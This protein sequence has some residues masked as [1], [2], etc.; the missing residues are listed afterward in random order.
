[1][2][3][4]VTIGIPVYMAVDY[5]GK[6]MESA[7]N[8]SYES[9]EY[10]I[11]DDCGK[12]GSIDIVEKI[13]SQHLRGKD[14]RILYNDQNCGV[15][16]TRN[17]ILEEAHGKYLYYLDSDDI[18]EPN[19]IMLLMDTIRKHKADVAYG[20]LERINLVGKTQTQCMILPNLFIDSEDGMATYAF[21]NYNSFPISVCNCLMS[22]AF[23]RNNNLHFINAAYWEDWAFTYDMVVKVGRAVLLSYITYHYQCRSG[24]LS[25]YQE[26]DYLEKKEILDNVSTM[27]YMKSRCY[28]LIGKDYLPYLC[29]NLEMNCFYIIC[30]IIK[31]YCRIIPHVSYSEMK[32]ILKYPMSSHEVLRY[33]YKFMPNLLLWLLSIIPLFMSLP[34]I[35]VAGRWKRVL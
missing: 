24:S 34:I 16:F 3:Y 25:H 28:S 17:R 26:R 33:K 1:M 8:Q 27:N 32:T 20:S 10:L 15:G 14:I 31:N 2:S 4:E 12:D 5:I 6:T 23:L 21:K 7:L 19:T 18:I 13:K 22:V 29:Y 9:I 30:H 11:I 35:W